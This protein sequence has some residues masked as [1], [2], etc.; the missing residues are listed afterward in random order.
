[1]AEVWRV[2]EIG[3]DSIRLGGFPSFEVCWYG[4]FTRT[5]MILSLD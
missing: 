2:L 3:L 4:D 5:T 1:V